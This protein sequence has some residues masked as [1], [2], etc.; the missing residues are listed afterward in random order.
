MVQAPELRVVGDA[1]LCIRVRQYVLEHPQPGVERVGFGQEI[2]QTTIRTTV[3]SL[4]PPR[5]R[6]TTVTAPPSATPTRADPVLGRHGLGVGVVGGGRKCAAGM[7][8]AYGPGS[9]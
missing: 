7:H 4:I 9:V 3:A 1:S 6:W 5:C 2:T 8:G